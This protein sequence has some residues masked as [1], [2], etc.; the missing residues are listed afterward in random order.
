MKKTIK[1]LSIALG[2]TLILS[3]C[4]TSSFTVGDGPQ[5]GIE[6]KKPNHYLLY[7]LA[8]ISISDPVSMAGETKDY[9]VTITH[10]PVD[11]LISILTLG[12]YTP[13]TTI[14]KR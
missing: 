7:G 12:L 11:N 1:T 5:R 8:P 4:Y 9:E 3:S 13:T 14:V 10:T 2:L 6:V